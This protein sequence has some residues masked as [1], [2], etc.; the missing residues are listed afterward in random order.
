MVLGLVE[1]ASADIFDKLESSGDL[2][3]Y[4]E[5]AVIKHDNSN[6]GGLTIESSGNYVD[7]ESVRFTGLNIGKD[8]VEDL[9]TL[10]N[11]KVTFTSTVDVTGALTAS[12]LTLG[13]TTITEDVLKELMDLVAQ[14]NSSEDSQ[15][16]CLKIQYNTLKK[17]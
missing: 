10:S 3:L 13:T 5:F 17:C 14:L 7:V 2:T 8:G 1:V 6:G 11:Q 4:G 15:A 9:I 12:S 16:E